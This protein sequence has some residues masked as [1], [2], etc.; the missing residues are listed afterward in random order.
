MSCWF[1]TIMEKK[2]KNK[3]RK[4]FVIEAS[5]KVLAIFFQRFITLILTSFSVKIDLTSTLAQISIKQFEE[6][7]VKFLSLWGT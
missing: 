2:K 4:K 1:N 6:H 5:T 7:S 3:Q